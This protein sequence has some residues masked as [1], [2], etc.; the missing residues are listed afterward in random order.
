MS[1]PHTS[2]R[3]AAFW[4]FTPTRLD[5]F[6]RWSEL[7]AEG[8]YH[9]LWVGQSAV[10]D[11][12]GAIAFAAGAGHQCPIGVA[13]QVI[14]M[15]N[16]VTAAQ[17][18]RGMAAATNTELRVCF[19]AGDPAA[20]MAFTGR[21][22]KS[23]LTATREFLTVLRAILDGE[24]LKQDGHYFSLAAHMPVEPP[25]TGVKLGLGT[26][27]PRMA[28][29]AGEIADA[30]VTWLT[31]PAYVR[32]VLVPALTDGATSAQRPRP[33]LIVP[34][35]AA[36]AAPDRDP[37]QIAQGAL[38]SH[39]RSSHYR[40]MLAR[41]GENAALRPGVDGALEARLLTYG[42]V[43]DIADRVVEVAAS[44]ADEIPL[45]LHQPGR[46]W[47]AIRDEW[48]SVGQAIAE[49]LASVHGPA[50]VPAGSRRA[51]TRQEVPV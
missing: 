31:P 16:P 23:P 25:A 11:T 19:S 39:L 1:T 35:H 47:S 10:I 30:A 21:R 33:E 44:G 15:H 45:V 5:A 8:P 13:V 46:S 3:L 32:D 48:L 29:L 2:P 12:A 18:I 38:G 6:I 22:F 41:A 9:R 49:R 24:P 42:T 43:D 37:R 36:L 51:R 20:Q 28:H 14:P 7:A 17:Q 40:E 34:V 4:P 50:P 27:R 26:L